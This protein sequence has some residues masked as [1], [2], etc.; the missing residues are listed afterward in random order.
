M[1]DGSLRKDLYYRLMRLTID[2]PPLREREGDALLLFEHF[3]RVYNEKHGTN[4]N[5]SPSDEGKSALIGYNFP[6]N[7][8]E[9]ESLIIRAATLG[10]YD[11]DYLRI[12]DFINCVDNKPHHAKINETAE[13]RFFNKLYKMVNTESKPLVREANRA[14][15]ELIID[16]FLKYEGN[17]SVCARALGENRPNLW[18]RLSKMGISMHALRDEYRRY[19]SDGH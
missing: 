7:V 1:E 14:M 10:Y 12:E 6:G 19:K 11:G 4:Y 15:L 17:F 3:V 5:H 9:L 13:I 8:R 16:N 2:V 18:Y